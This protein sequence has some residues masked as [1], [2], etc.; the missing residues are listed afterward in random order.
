MTTA[1]ILAAGKGTRMKSDLPKVLHPIYGRSLLAW[2]A[3]CAVQAGVSN[4]VIV[5]GHGK[6]QV[7]KEF[8][9]HAPNVNF[10]FV[11]QAEQLGTGHAVQCVLKDTS[12]HLDDTCLILYG[13][14]PAIPPELIEFLLKDSPEALSLVTGLLDD[15]YGYGRI[16]RNDQKIVA[17]REEVD[18]NTDEKGIREVNPGIY[19]ARTEFLRSTTNQLESDNNAS[20][21]YLT[22]LVAG[23]HAQGE[24]VRH[25]Q[26]DMKLLGG[27]NTQAQLSNLRTALRRRINQAHAERGVAL[28]DIDRIDI[29]ISVE[30]EPGVSVAPNVTLRGRTSI[31]KG[32]RIDCG[33][34]LED[35]VVKNNANLKPYV[36]AAKKYDR[37]GGTRRSFCTPPPANR[38]GARHTHW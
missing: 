27:V 30:I 33:C 34:V 29:D 22:D 23:A 6:D 4:L 2:S 28:A 38:F 36:V 3:H 14:C 5:T 37:A 17:I 10:S 7:E 18:C 9:A 15:P 12:V 31:E 8:A 35:V 26:A 11:H 1:I 20:E 21:F 32:A 16:I 13:D 19:F 24:E 25:I